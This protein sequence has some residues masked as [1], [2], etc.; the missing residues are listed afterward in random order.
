[1]TKLSDKELRR[2]YFR[3]LSRYESRSTDLAVVPF[4][5]EDVRSYKT[6]EVGW[7]KKAREALFLSADS[8]AATI[9]VIRAAYSKYEECET[10]GAIT[11]ETLSRAAEA[12][13]CELVYAIRPKSK[14]RFS[15]LIWE[16]LLTR[17]SVHPW[18]KKCDQR[19]RGEALAARA[20]DVMNDSEFRRQ[21]GW[22]QKAN[23]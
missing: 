15:F 21:Q 17:A 19:R 18:L 10:R 7:L 12:M 9:V 13:D 22:S 2:A 1:M 20:I 6:G 4:L 11:L 23:R 8:I 16:A 3:W 5:A 14:T